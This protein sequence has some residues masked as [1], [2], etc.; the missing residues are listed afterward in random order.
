LK[1]ASPFQ[2]LRRLLGYIVAAV[3]VI[4]A[5]LLTGVR[6]VLPH[7]AD[8]RAHVEHWVSGYVGHP[9]RIE[10]MDARL[11]VLSPTLVLDGV[12]LVA[13]GGS[14]PL[15]RFDSIHIGLAPLA[16][17]RAGRLVMDDLTVIG[18]RLAVQRR[19]DGELRVEGLSLPERSGPREDPL[20]VGRWLLAQQRLRLRES[21]L[22]WRDELA[23]SERAFEQVSLELRNDGDRHRM[24]ATLHLPE[25]LGS[26]LQVAADLEGDLLHLNEVTGD[27]Y[28][29]VERARPAGVLALLPLSGLPTAAGEVSARAW[30]RWEGRLSAMR[31]D[32]QVANLHITGPDGPFALDAIGA[33]FAWAHSAA[34]NT[35]ELADLR[36]TRGGRP[37]E[38][39]RLQLRYAADAGQG[40]G[41]LRLQANFLRLEDLSAAASLFPL[42]PKHR[43]TLRALDAAGD[44]RDVHVDWDGARWNAGAAFRDLALAP[45][46]RRPGVD[47]LDGY[48]WYA[49]GEAGLRLAT[50]DGQILL[51]RLFRDP[52]PLTRLTGEARLHRDGPA[53]RLVARDVAAENDDIGARANLALT[54][55]DQ[56]SPYL[57]LVGDFRDGRAT[58]VYRYLPAHV[59]PEATVRW[60]DRAFKEGRVRAGG[61]VF[62]GR[63]GD[64]PFDRAPGRFEVRFHA[65][66]VQLDYMPRWPRLH[67]IDGEVVF[68]GRGMHIQASAARLL[69]SEVGATAVSIPDLRRARLQVK[70]KVEGPFSD[71]LDYLKI[72]GLA[73]EFDDVLARFRG[74]G[75]SVLSLDLE[76]P[77]GKSSGPG[78]VGGAVQFLDSRLQVAEGVEFTDIHG[79]LE[80]DGKDY[81]ADSIAARLFDEPVR[82]SVAPH[83]QA[84]E[85]TFAGTALGET[86]AARFPSP[87]S[88]RL[89]GRAAWT[90]R[91]HIAGAGGESLLRIQSP[92]EGMA[93]ELPAPL[94]K[95]AEEKQALDLTAYFTGERANQIELVL[96]QRAGAVW[97][98]QS[99]G[100]ITRAAVHLGDGRATLPQE[101]SLL[102]TGRLTGF[103]AA[104]WTGLLPQGPAVRGTT[105]RTAPLPVR[106]HLEELDVAMAPGGAAQ[107]EARVWDDELLPPMSVRVEQ[108]TVAGKPLGRLHFEA[109][110]GPGQLVMREFSLRGRLLEVSGSGHWR[111]G[112]VPRTQLDM[113]VFSPDLGSLARSFGLASTIKKGRLTAD[114]KLTWPGGPQDYDLAITNGSARVKVRD[115]ILEEVEPGAGRL[116]GLLS[117]EA[118][119]RRLMLDFRDMFEKGVRF[120]RFEGDFRLENGNAYTNNLHLDTLPA[121]IFVNGRTGLARRDYDHT[122]TV[123]PE[124]AGTLPVAGGIALGPQVGAVLLLFQSIFKKQIDEAALIRYTVTGPWEKPVVT[125]LDKK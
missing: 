31:G 103:S 41:P 88:A 74:G 15:A 58:S 82:V 57:D 87:L 11:L 84:S 34:G 77:L 42:A 111:R 23:G 123:V 113:T 116:L 119:P 80:F 12:A 22:V 95:P 20:A 45:D 105:P 55:P 97:E 92:L 65:E 47:G 64:F 73:G 109:A 37:W 46:G 16:S 21:R 9:V 72:S 19:E 115:G 51:P 66:D 7:A 39:T 122:I 96:P 69:G 121:G 17:L 117:L 91:L 18:A 13:P 38:P 2:R 30:G 68:E 36:V 28:A 53:W 62:H 61:V 26:T 81:R 114:A 79:T 4:A 75:R 59:M 67:G 14:E 3:L 99:D 1:P 50:V 63:L 98:R 71:L 27:L 102:I 54:L 108:L 44:L 60:L 125:R 76:Q 110:P 10:R 118:L 112:P 8:Y 120:R 100:K 90:G 101:S 107:G 104:A 85:I 124:V 29:A 40:F 94:G 48:A 6:L 24:N 106:L 33:R 93:V 89:H 49:Q 78:R 5:V 83:D 25:D 35:F 32:F 56:G 86:L 43:S 52:L 70:G